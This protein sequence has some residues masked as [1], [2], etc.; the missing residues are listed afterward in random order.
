MAEG[1]Q[2]RP[3]LCSGVGGKRC[4]GDEKDN[5]RFDCNRQ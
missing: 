1:A 5:G 4:D 3:R 2:G